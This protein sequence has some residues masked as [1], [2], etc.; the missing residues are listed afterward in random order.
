MAVAAMNGK[1]IQP[2]GVPPFRI[3]VSPS[4]HD[5]KIVPLGSPA[6]PESP[7]A[8]AA[9]RALIDHTDLGPAG[10]V[11]EALTIAARICIYTNEEITVE[12]LE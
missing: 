9:A 1:D 2:P 5:A 4:Q 12:E 7:Y 6:I 8:S 10:V 3:F 11:Q